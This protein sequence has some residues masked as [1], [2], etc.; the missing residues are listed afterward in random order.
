MSS[1]STRTEVEPSLMPRALHGRR[2]PRLSLRRRSADHPMVMFAILAGAGFASMAFI[3]TTGPA[4]ATLGAPMKLNEDARTTARLAGIPLKETDIVCR[5]QEWTGESDACMR[6]MA[7]QS[8]V[9]VSRKVRK[10]ASAEPDA[11]VP[12]IF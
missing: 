10:L 2:F 4:F 7:E 8:G 6:M 3:P 1:S 11:T 9:D 12:N 5:G